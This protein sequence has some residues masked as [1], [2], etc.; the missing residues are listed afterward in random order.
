MFRV[1]CP[2]DVNFKPTRVG[3][4]IITSKFYVSSLGFFTP[5]TIDCK[6]I[7]YL[8]VNV[9]PFHNT[10][11]VFIHGKYPVKSMIVYVSDY[12]L[13]GNKCLLSWFYNTEKLNPNLRTS[14]SETSH[15]LCRHSRQS[16]QCCTKI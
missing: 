9:I 7:L 6:W 12:H 2:V 13:E 4:T 5:S 14:T 1:F 11:E 8:H 10:T 3:M 15:L 16:R